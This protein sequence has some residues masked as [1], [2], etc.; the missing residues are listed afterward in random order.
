MP[1]HDIPDSNTRDFNEILLTPYMAGHFNASRLLTSKIVSQPGKWQINPM[2]GDVVKLQGCKS[3]VGKVVR[4]FGIDK[5][6][7][8]HHPDIHDKVFR[9]VITIEPLSPDGFS[10]NDDSD[11]LII[12]GQPRRNYPDLRGRLLLTDNDEVLGVAAMGDAMTRIFATAA[13]ELPK[14]VLRQP[15]AFA[16]ALEA[17]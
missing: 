8:P 5:A 3:F 10:Y 1:Q 13:W 16:K 9:N 4:L 11:D 12:P 6:N 14:L 2:P 17:Q 7:V 15:K